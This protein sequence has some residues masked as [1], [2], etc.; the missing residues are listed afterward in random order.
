MPRIKVYY[1]TDKM[2]KPLVKFKKRAA[3]FPRTPEAL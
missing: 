2:I 3:D 1:N